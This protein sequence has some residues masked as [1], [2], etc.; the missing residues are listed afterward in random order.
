MIP[1]VQRAPVPVDGSNGPPSDSN[2]I[3]TW[4]IMKAVTF[5][6]L[7]FAHSAALMVAATISLS[8][9]RPD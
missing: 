2:S 5:E 7:L 3:Y 8:T 4:L 1:L 6:G 9:D